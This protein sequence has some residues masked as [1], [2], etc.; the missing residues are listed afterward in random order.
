[1]GQKCIQLPPRCS[2][3]FVALGIPKKRFINSERVIHLIVYLVEYHNYEREERGSTRQCYPNKHSSPSSFAN[4]MWKQK[5]NDIITE[6]GGQKLWQPHFDKTMSPE[7]NRLSD[8]SDTVACIRTS[9][10]RWISQ[11]LRKVSS[12]QIVVS[13]WMLLRRTTEKNKLYSETF[14][15]GLWKK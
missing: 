8:L 11:C 13:N 7:A 6:D 12:G 4:L 14:S 10:I 3:V 15:R 2:M 9:K 5:R 1:M